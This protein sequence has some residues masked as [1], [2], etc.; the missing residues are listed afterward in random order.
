MKCFF[1]SLE[2]EE[3][4]DYLVL[5]TELYGS[6]DTGYALLVRSS[7]D[8][9]I[10][11]FKSNEDDDNL[12]DRL[13]DINE[14]PEILCRGTLLDIEGTAQFYY[15]RPKLKSLF[16]QITATYYEAA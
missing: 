5:S 13:G 12:N 7:D 6:D 14:W 3:L 4:E 15:S 10:V 8:A 11:R 1:D 9:V 2:R 16:D